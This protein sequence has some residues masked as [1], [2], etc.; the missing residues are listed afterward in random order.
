M[1]QEPRH[2]LGRVRL[3]AILLAVALLAVSAVFILPRVWPRPSP[4]GAPPPPDKPLTTA[5]G[6]VAVNEGEPRLDTQPGPG[7]AQLQ[8]PQPVPTAAGEPLTDEEVQRIFARLPSLTLEHEDRL[9]F[10]LPPESLPPPRTGE[11]IEEPFPPP[12]DPITPEP[13]DS[14]PLQVLRFAPEGEIPL[15]PFVNVTFNQ[16]MAPLATLGQLADQDVPVTL[17]PEVPG[18]WRWVGTKTLVFEADSDEIDRL[19]KATEYQVTVPAGTRSMVGGVLAQ[20]VRWSFTTPPPLMT[21]YSPSYGPQP[22]DPLFFIAFDQRVDPAAVLKTVAVT[23]DGKAVRIQLATAEQLAADKQV[24]RMAESALEGR[25]LAFRAKELLPADAAIAVVIG[26]GTPSAEGPLVTQAAQAFDFRT[27]APLRIDD[28]GCSWSDDE[29][30]PLT[31]LYIQFNNPLDAVAFD[32]A[33][34]DVRPEIPGAIVDV[35]GNTISIRGATKG[36]TTY[37]VT[38]DGAIRDE[39]GQTLGQDARLTFRIGRAEPLLAGP[40]SVL[41]TLDPAAEKPAFTVY[42]LNHDRLEVQIYAAQPSHW[43]AFKKYIA[44]S[45]QQDPAPKPPGRLALDEN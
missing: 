22:R 25:W 35:Y 45:Y 26:P 28:H 9:Q 21:S 5:E 42:A 11:T 29:C 39:F 31:P 44:D 23:A 27:Y 3:S 16:P 18:T 38:V 1:A 17:E 13:V 32:E 20:T 6:G 10:R 36:S 14:G 2:P 30:R 8:T 37:R 24:A 43:P 41:V 34:L 12:P 40:D 4:D 19:P 33:W 15:A 7:Q